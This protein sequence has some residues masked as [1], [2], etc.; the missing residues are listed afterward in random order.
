MDRVFFCIFQPQNMEKFAR[1]YVKIDKSLGSVM[2]DPNI[3][4]GRG[5]SS[6][7]RLVYFSLGQAR[8][9]PNSRV[10]LASYQNLCDLSGISS[11]QT[12]RKCLKELE[13]NGFLISNTSKGQSTSYILLKGIFFGREE[14]ETSS[15]SVEPTSTVS[16]EVSHTCKEHVLSSRSISPK[17]SRYKQKLQQGPAGTKKEDVVV[18]FNKNE[19]KIGRAHV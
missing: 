1:Y 13:A 9:N 4:K 18:F 10:S 19:E 15:L 3:N 7:A 16:V 6:L 5:L 12:I 8:M 14:L 17:R 11:H 2:A